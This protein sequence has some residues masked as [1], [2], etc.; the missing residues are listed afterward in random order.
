[1]ACVFTSGRTEPCKDAIGGLT[2]AYA[3]DYVTSA[4]TVVAGEATAIAAGLTVTYD[5]VLNGNTNT[6]NETSTADNSAGTTTYAQELILHLKKQTKASANEIHLLLKARPIWVVKTRNGDYQVVGLTDG[7]NGTGVTNSGGA[8]EEFN[9]YDLTF[10]ATETEP[11]P[12]LDSSTVTAFIALISG[13]N[14]SP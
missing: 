1:M 2:N 13:T 10:T 8:K 4:F 6:F 11:A 3:C 5:Y 12:Y 9:G 14:V 7:T